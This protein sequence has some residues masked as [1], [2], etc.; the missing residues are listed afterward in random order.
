MGA[1]SV[2]GNDRYRNPFEPLLAPVTRLP[3]GEIEPLTAID[4][5]IGAVIVEPIQAE[6][7]VRIPCDAFLPALRRRCSEVGALLLV[8]EVLTGFGRTGA[9]WASAHWQVSPDILILAKALGGGWNGDV[10]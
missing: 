2:C 10:Q 7:G 6:G 9:L 3:F 8:D 4:E 5:T 1:L